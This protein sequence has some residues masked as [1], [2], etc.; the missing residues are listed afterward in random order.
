MRSRTAAPPF[1]DQLADGSA[2]ETPG[3]VGSEPGQ[4]VRPRDPPRLAP[5]GDKGGDD[6]ASA[7][8][9]HALPLFDPREDTRETIAGSRTVA[10]LMVRHH[11]SRDDDRQGDRRL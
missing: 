7:A 2:L 11:V 9:F 1:V 8:D 4:K 6:A 10:R 5:L 3:P